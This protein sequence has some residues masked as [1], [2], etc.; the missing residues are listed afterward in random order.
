MTR[1]NIAK[2][3]NEMVAGEAITTS[4]VQ[5]IFKTRDGVVLCCGDV[6]E[7]TLEAT[8]DTYAPGCIYIRVST[9]STTTSYIYKNSGTMA[10]PDFVALST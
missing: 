2:E 9:V 5:T 8:D 10:S 6:A 4:K 7:A 3:L 1:G